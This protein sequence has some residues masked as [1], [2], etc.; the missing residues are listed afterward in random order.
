[1]SIIGER[2]R[3]TQERVIAFFHN[4]LGYRYLGNWKDREGNDNV[5]EELLTDWLKR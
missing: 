4:A 3:Q 5:E 2:A 1:M